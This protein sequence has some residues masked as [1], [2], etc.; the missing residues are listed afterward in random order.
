MNNLPIE[1]FSYKNATPKELYDRLEQAIEEQ[2]GRRYK[3]TLQEIKDRIKY[4]Y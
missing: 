4:D 1:R 3:R 2:D